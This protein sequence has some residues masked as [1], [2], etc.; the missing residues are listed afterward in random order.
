MSTPDHY[1]A[2]NTEKY[3]MPKTPFFKIKTDIKEDPERD[4]CTKINF[5]P[6]PSPVSYD[7]HKS[8]RQTSLFP[9]PTMW[10]CSKEKRIT[11]IE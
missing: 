3:K 5:K 7:Q 9:N 1:D 4:R 11:V 2:L 10:K 8:F 6:G